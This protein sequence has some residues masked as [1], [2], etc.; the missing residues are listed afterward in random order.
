MRQK[1][2]K[3]ISTRR[4]PNDGITM[5]CSK[6]TACTPIMCIGWLLDTWKH[7]H[8]YKSIVWLTL[9]SRRTI[10]HNHIFSHLEPPHCWYLENNP[11]SDNV[12]SLTPT[13][14]HSLYCDVFAVAEITK[15]HI[16]CGFSYLFLLTPRMACLC[17]SVPACWT[18]PWA[19]TKPRI[20]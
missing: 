13:L 5:N 2:E 16:L 6:P 8:L 20:H 9:C 7:T 4:P 17:P 14:H 10:A 1:P 3:I 12:T 18:S 19:Q 15:L 11:S